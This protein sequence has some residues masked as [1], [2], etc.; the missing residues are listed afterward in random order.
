MSGN[1]SKWIALACATTLGLSTGATALDEETSAPAQG[2]SSEQELAERAYHNAQQTHLSGLQAADGWYT[3]EGGLRW[4]YVTYLGL[5]ESPTPAD[6]VTVHYEGSFID[7]NVFDSSYSRGQPA[8][9]PLSGLIPAWEL[10]IPQ[11]RVGETIELAAPS[12]LAY[13]PRGRGGRIPGGATLL[14]K[15]ELIGIEGR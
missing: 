15:V 4:R 9:F 10:A 11:M 12:N 1:T 3:M 8:T 6:T 2:P 5:G 13:G 14:F 7:G